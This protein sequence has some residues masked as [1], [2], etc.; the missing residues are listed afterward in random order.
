MRQL[1]AEGF[2]KKA[3]RG[4]YYCPKKASFGDVPPEDQKLVRAFLK[5]GDFYI[6]SLNAYNALGVGTTQLYNERLVYNH[7]RKGRFTLDGRP[8]HF[9]KRS[10]FPKRSSPEFLLVDLIN[11][12]DFLAEDKEKLCRNV[13]RKV[14]SMDR[15][16]LRKAVRDYAGA[17]ARKFFEGAL[18]LTSQNLF[19]KKICGK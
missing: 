5:G 4:I 13:A 10:R 9:L 16:K 18:A 12:L 19:K 2:L 14:L 11:N 15:A 7:K 1:V 8:F 6:A 3:A 17:R